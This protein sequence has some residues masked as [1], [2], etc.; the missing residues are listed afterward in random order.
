MIAGG[1]DYAILPPVMEVTM[2]RATLTGVLLAL[3]LVVE[4][5]AVSTPAEAVSIN[6]SIGSSV[7]GGRAISCAEGA[8]RV[9]DR[10]FR[11]VR[12]IDCSGRYFIYRGWRGDR[13]YEIAV[14]RINGRVV[15]VHR[16]GRR[17]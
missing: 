16:I 1:E 8:R 3:F 15:D 9:R 11:N 4:P 2:S 13:Q 7:S 12:R 10:G 17:R 5:L 6:I 14:R